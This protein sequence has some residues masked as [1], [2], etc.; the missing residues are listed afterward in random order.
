MASESETSTLI[1]HFVLAVCDPGRWRGVDRLAELDL[2]LAQAR[3]LFSVVRHAEP[4]P[5]HTIAGDLGLS[6]TA[7]GRNVDRLVRLDLLTR[8]E[9]PT[10]RR[11]KLVGLTEHG[12]H[13]AWD[14][15]AIHRA[16]ID[17]VVDRLP[18]ALREDLGRVL[19][20]VLESGAIHNAVAR[21]PAS[22]GD[23]S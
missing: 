14:Q 16:T 12:H 18:D 15:I 6:M 13:L 19:A 11:V 8:Q 21:P 2:T 1:E 9:S 4:Q 20:A 10:D 17:K 5:I 3:V 23:N 22:S 7:A